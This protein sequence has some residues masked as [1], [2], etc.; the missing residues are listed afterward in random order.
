VQS[1]IFIKRRETK[2]TMRRKRRNQSAKH[3]TQST[4]QEGERTPPQTP[5]QQEKGGGGRAACGT[6]AH[7][8]HTHI[9]GRLPSRGLRRRSRDVEQNDATREGTTRAPPSS[10]S[11][12]RRRQA[13]TLQTKW[14]WG[15]NSNASSEVNYANERNRC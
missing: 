11:P 14:H 5:D 7:Q 9:I 8:E 12:G 15:R 4:V 3:S 1:T 6:Q 2:V 13:F 10:V